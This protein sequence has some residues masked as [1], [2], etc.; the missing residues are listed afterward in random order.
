MIATSTDYLLRKWPHA[1]FCIALAFKNG[2][3]TRYYIIQISRLESHVTVQVHMH[4]N[5]DFSS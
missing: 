2:Y 1:I 5:L 4:H 3:I